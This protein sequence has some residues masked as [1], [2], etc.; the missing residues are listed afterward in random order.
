M[1]DCT[2]KISNFKLNI[3]RNL[4]EQSLIVDNQLMI[5]FSP[6]IIKSCTFSNS[7]TFLKLWTTPL[8]NLIN[9]ENNDI[10]LFENKK[11]VNENN[12][13]TFNFY[14][15]KGDLFQKYLSVHTANTVDLEFILHKK[16][17][18]YQAANITISSKLNNNNSLVTNF[19]LTTEELISNKRK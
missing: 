13:P 5:E 2:I 14:I 8:S 18:K 9:V 17:D 6:E 16:D 7:K 3:F 19:I 15:L 12:F 11:N 1:E 4:L 10:D